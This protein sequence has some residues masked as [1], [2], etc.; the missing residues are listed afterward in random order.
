[1]KLSISSNQIVRKKTAGLFLLLLTYLLL[2]S[3]GVFLQ[4]QGIKNYKLKDDISQKGLNAYQYDFLYLSNLIEEGFPQLDSIFPKN[5]RE[6]QVQQIVENLSTV[7]NNAN[8]VVQARRYLSNLKNQHTTIDL[9]QEFK[10][11]YPYV[12]HISSDNWYL[13]NLPKQFDSLQ[14]SKKMIKLNGVSIKDVEY[15]L[16]NY[17]FAENKINQQSEICDEQFYNKPE[18]LKEIGVIKEVSDILKLEFDDQTVIELA[19][20]ST[21]RKIDLFDI[22]FREHPITKYQ[23]ETYLYTINKKNNFGYLQFNQSHDKIDILEFIE[24]YV[25]PWLQPIARSY[26][27][28][29]FRKAKPSKLLA[30]SYNPKY[31]VFKDFVWELVDSLN[32]NKVENL[33]IDL[34]NNSGGNTTLGKQLMYFLT[35][36]DTIK[37]FADFVFTSEM[38]KKYFKKEYQDLEKKYPAG[39]PQRDLVPTNSSEN[40]FFDITN[41]SSKYFI[42]KNRPIF[43]GNVYVLANYG[44][45]S[46][47]AMLTTLIQ[48]NG[49]GKVIGTS[50]GNNPIGATT[51][52]PMKLPKT[53]A[54]ISIATSYIERPKKDKGK[55][56]MPDIWIEYTISDF[57]NGKDPYFENVTKQIKEKVS[58]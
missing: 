35:D 58:H 22:S 2:S 4:N 20:I 32:N 3:C 44:T 10:S 9:K 50:V 45:G 26:V 19:P 14:I 42:Q 31:P 8:F 33:I 1:M 55:I 41:S 23:N 5:Q 25:K 13:L 6:K 7:D 54:E 18:Y 38:Y 48:D 43:K 49:I 12:I 28:R 29:Q 30:S 24:S 47:A 27:K 51:Y 39:V 57:L 16:I 36:N 17:T 56:Q 53:K 21:K 34:R 11:V 40:L 52:T 46:S 15:N 37:G